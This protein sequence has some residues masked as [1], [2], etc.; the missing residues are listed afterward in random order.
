ME[1][2][3]SGIGIGAAFS[4]VVVGT[5]EAVRPSADGYTRV[6]LALEV[7]LRGQAA[8]QFFYPT[9]DE[10]DRFGF[11][12]GSRYVVALRENRVGP[13]PYTD[14]CSAT[15][16]LATERDVDE[17]IAMASE[18]TVIEWP[19]S[20]NAA[21]GTRLDVV[22]AAVAIGAITIAV[23]GGVAAHTLRRRRRAW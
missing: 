23:L 4:S 8:E 16:A 21:A 9:I 13:G 6:E 15:Q 18:P 22:W 2:T 7:V 11:E 17:L 12:V 10:A 19:P 20:R 14:R 3:V 5:I 1:A